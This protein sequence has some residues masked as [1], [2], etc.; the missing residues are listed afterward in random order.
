MPK[1]PKVEESAFSANQFLYKLIVPKSL[2][3]R[4][5]SESFCS[6]SFIGFFSF[7]I[8]NMVRNCGE[9]H[10]WSKNPEHY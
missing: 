6:E 4:S 1:V 2:S 9:K 8:L 10:L 3:G 7:V 5:G